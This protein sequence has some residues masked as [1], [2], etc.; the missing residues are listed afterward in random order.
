MTKSLSY[1]GLIL[2]QIGFIIF[3]ITEHHS[4]AGLVGIFGLLTIG[5]DIITDLLKK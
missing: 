4:L 1:I 3:A 5:Y 2:W